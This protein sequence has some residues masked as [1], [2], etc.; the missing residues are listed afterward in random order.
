MLAASFEFDDRPGPLRDRLVRDQ[1]DWLDTLATVFASGITEGQFRADADP[2]Q[3]AQDLE[4]VM[5]AFHLTNRLLE[6]PAAAQRTR[7]ALETLL[8]A[9]RA[10]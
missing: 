10:G 2:R 1:R 8:S 7:R 6:D 3:F 4:G 5:L 9:A